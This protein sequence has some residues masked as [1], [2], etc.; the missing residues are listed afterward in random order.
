MLR[1]GHNPND[2]SPESSSSQIVIP[3][4][5]SYDELHPGAR[6]PV[7]SEVSNFTSVS[8]RPMNPNWQ[9]GHGGEFN[10][11]GPPPDRRQQQRQDVLFANNP[12]FE[13]PGMI[14]PRGRGGY[15][16][17][18]GSGMGPTSYRGPMRPPPP[19][20]L[21]NMGVD[22]RYPAPAPPPGSQ[23]GPGGGVMREI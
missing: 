19:S 10:S 5:L 8:Q 12:D 9:P 14:G 4:T 22:G 11:L 20:V 15:R 23:I 1:P 3:R 16:G 2:P 18:G 6:S 17:R 7:D 13:L 21:D